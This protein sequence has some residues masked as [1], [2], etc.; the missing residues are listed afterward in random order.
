MMVQNTPP[1]D[2]YHHTYSHHHECLHVHFVCLELSDSLAV[3]YAVKIAGSYELYIRVAS[4]IGRWSE[5]ERHTGARDYP[6][7]ITF[8]KRCG[9]QAK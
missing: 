6:Y 8:P 2:K 5:D 9:S 1:C 7:G 3:H 4:R